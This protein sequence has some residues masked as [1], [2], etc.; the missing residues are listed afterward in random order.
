MRPN[1]AWRVALCASFAAN[2]CCA[3]ERVTVDCSKTLYQTS[4]LFFGINTLFW[5][6]D[7]VSRQDG[8]YEQAISSLGVRLLRYP[9]GMGGTNFHW[10]ET[11]LDKIDQFPYEDG[12]EKMDFDE[13]MEV[14]RKTNAEPMVV[15]N[16]DSWFRDGNVAGGA[17]EAADWVRACREKGYRVKR[18]E[19]GNETYHHVLMGATEYAHLLVTYAKAMKDVDPS[20]QIGANGHWDWQDVGARDRAD[21]AHYEELR[22]A[23]AGVRGKVETEA[24]KALVRKRVEQDRRKGSPQWWPTLL[25]TAGPHIDFAIV[26]WYFNSAQ[27]P[28]LDT[29]V[30]ELDALLVKEAGRRLP[31]ALTEWN[32]GSR[33]QKGMSR[34]EH[35][36]VI[37]EAAA[38]FMDSGV[39]MAAYWPARMRAGNYTLMAYKDN[40]ITDT[41]RLF[42]LLA[43]NT[44]ARRVPT[45]AALS[46]ACVFA[47]AN[48]AN[49]QLCVLIVN[50]EKQ[51]HSG[52]TLEVAGSSVRSL[53]A[54]VLTEG[55]PE[56]AVSA[57]PASSGSGSFVISIPARSCS[58][59]STAIN[60]E[61]AVCAETPPR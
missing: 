54:R 32:I 18:W 24:F 53:S 61:T 16:T 41:G 21:P 37:A 10:R 2:A 33:M 11:R 23:E 34:F 56:G 36:L 52:V 4:P 48:A 17:A 14:C 9:G 35:D 40:S 13:F 50:Q 7:D 43:H 49:D 60:S 5:I 29:A 8:S 59:I 30:R 55:H 58:F 1:C 45:A 15:V 44:L 31:I 20:I 51:T 25:E 28:Q 27:L 42:S 46:D 19:I 38:R 22:E 6:D 47:T 12:P 57:V 39:D 26:H 3:A